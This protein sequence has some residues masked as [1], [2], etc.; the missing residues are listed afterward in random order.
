MQRAFDV[1][2]VQC[3]FGTADIG[4]FRVVNPANAV[5]L[6]CHLKTM[7]QTGK[8]RQGFQAGRMRNTDCIRQRQRRQGIGVVMA[9]CQWHLTGIQDFLAT[10]T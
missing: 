4:R 10:H 6:P 8:G 7:S 9:S 2:T 1:Q 3:G 5:M